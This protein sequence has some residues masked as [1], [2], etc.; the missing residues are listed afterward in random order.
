MEIHEHIE[1]LACEL[2]EDGKVIL[3][4]HPIYY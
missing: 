2:N 3:N 4:F 1:Q